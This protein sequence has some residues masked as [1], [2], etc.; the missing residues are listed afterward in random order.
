MLCKFTCVCFNVTVHAH[1]ISGKFDV[2]FFPILTFYVPLIQWRIQDFPV[3]SQG[4]YVS[5]ILY[6]KTIESGPLGGMPGARPPKSANMIDYGTFKFH[7][8][9]H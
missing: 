8:D 5:Q 4:G 2:Y 1:E 9:M 7:T 3:D 6:V